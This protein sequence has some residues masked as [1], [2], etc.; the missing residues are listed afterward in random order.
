MSIL[1]IRLK[2]VIKR[3]FNIKFHLDRRQ[4]RLAYLPEHKTLF[5]HTEHHMPLT[6][7]EKALEM[8][9]AFTPEHPAWGVRELGTHLDFSPSTVQ[10]LLQPLKSY[11]FVEQDDETKKYRLGTIYYHFLHTLQSAFPIAKAAMPYMKKLMLNTG[12]TVHLNV[13]EGADRICIDTIESFKDLKASM[14]IGSRSPLHAGASSKCLIAFS[15]DAFIHHHLTHNVLTPL[16][17][18]TITNADV[19]RAALNKIRENGYAISL[20]ERCPGL[21]SISAPVFDHTKMAKAAISLAIPE[22]RFRDEKHLAF[23]IEKT[24][25]TTTVFSKS[26]GCTDKD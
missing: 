9:I 25:A 22:L 26:L 6:S 14:P 8:L 2:A 24:L 19:F 23:C 15:D 10:R 3:A 21:G 4:S 1:P 17:E 20:G 11:G 7:I 13:I 12:E 16:T 5:H 18:K